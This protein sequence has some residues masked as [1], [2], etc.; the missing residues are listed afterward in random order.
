MMFVCVH[1]FS[2]V[3]SRLLGVAFLGGDGSTPTHLRI[4]DYGQSAAVHIQAHDL[5]A[6]QLRDQ[7]NGMK[8]QRHVKTEGSLLKSSQ[9]LS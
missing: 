2:V 7:M 5:L 1:D 3:P 6:F 8:Q 9:T 4:R